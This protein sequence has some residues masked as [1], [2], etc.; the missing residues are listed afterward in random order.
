MVVGGLGFSSGRDRSLPSARLS[1]ISILLAFIAIYAFYPSESASE[2]FSLIVRLVAFGAM[3]FLAVALGSA[4]K[5]VLAVFSWGALFFVLSISF[6]NA[7]YFSLRVLNSIAAT[8]LAAA[9]VGFTVSSSIRLI[10]LRVLDILLVLAAFCIFIQIFVYLGTGY[11]VEIHGLFFPWGLSRS[12]EI[13]KF[14]IAR[15]SGMFTEP[16]THS[17]YVF[18]LLICRAF[19]SGSVFHRIGVLSVAS[20]ASTLSVWGVGVVLVYGISYFVAAIE[21]GKTIRRFLVGGLIA[22]VSLF[23][24]YVTLPDVF[25]EN[26]VQYFEVRTQLTDGSG[27]SKVAAWLMAAARFDE[28]A[29]IGLPVTVDFCEGCYSPQDAGLV[30]SFSM[31]FGILSAFVFF[32][33]YLL[34]LYFAGGPGLLIFGVPFLFS[35]FFYFDPLV[36]IIFFSALVH[37]LRKRFG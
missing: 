17:V 12:A 3:A 27:S 31:Y 19:L 26:I 24:A 22:L 14:G 34:G 20:I 36:W 5:E 29:A 15:L 37:L 8:I 23:V 10:C 16:G 6:A 28:V 18:G 11:I 35:K 2:R 32:F 7:P 1:V 9:V 30:L 21:N 4:R 33:L 25:I 13:E